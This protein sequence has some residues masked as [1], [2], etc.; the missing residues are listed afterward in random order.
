MCAVCCDRQCDCSPLTE[1]Q[2]LIYFERFYTQP[3]R[4]WWTAVTGDLYVYQKRHQSSLLPFASRPF[5]NCYKATIRVEILIH[6]LIGCDTQILL[7]RLV[8][9]DENWNLIYSRHIM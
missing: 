3:S 7:L 4:I 6:T 9:S 1:I 8:V 5:T 2:L